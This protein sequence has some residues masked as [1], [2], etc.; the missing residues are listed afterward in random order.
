[1][2]EALLPP[3][4]DPAGAVALVVLSA[5]TGAVSAAV[6]IG[7]GVML[8][9]AMTFVL[10]VAALVPVH[11]VVQFG[12]NV[13]RLAVLAKHAAWRFLAPFLGGAVLGAVA[14][15]ALVTDLPET[16]LLIVIG[17]F[18][19]VMAWV[20]VPPLGRGE[21]SVIAAGGLLST[22]LTMFVGAT[23]P[24]VITLFRQSGL[25]HTALVA[26]NAAAMAAQHVL[27]VAAFAAL[28]FAFVPWAPL[29]V[30]MVGAGFLGTVL[31]ARLL[32]RL[33]ERTLRRALSVVLTVIGLHLVARAV[34][35]LFG[36]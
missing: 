19:T 31:G 16:A 25:D 2:I 24:F 26:T 28:G 32:H 14:G 12:S 30:G 36:I 34:V 20:K 13:G 23:G 10:P 11:A 22:V 17:V 5:F 33:P 15:G 27:K 21:R 3:A 4:V 9:A 35:T 18:V 1:M 29:M 7:G 8:L 6:G